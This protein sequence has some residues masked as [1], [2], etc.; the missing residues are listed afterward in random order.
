MKRSAGLV[1][2]LGLS[3]LLGACSGLGG[4]PPIVATL[5]INTPRPTLDATALA[6][7]HAQ[8]TPATPVGTPLRRRA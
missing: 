3:L 7:I 8:V 1:A 6:Q 2:L 5:A 4:E